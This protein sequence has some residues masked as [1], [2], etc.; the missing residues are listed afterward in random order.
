M[1][2]GGS[3][4]YRLDQLPG[5]VAKVYVSTNKATLAEPKRGSNRIKPKKKR[6]KK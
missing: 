4:V 3:G 2:V 5:G 1:R 6:N